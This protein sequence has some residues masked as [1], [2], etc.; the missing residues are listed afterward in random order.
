MQDP[1]RSIT[2]PT[3]DHGEVTLPEPPW[4]LGA[5]VHEPGGYRADILH[6]GPEQTIAFRGDPISEAGLVQLPYGSTDPELGSPTPGVSVSLVQLTLDPVGLY[7]L[8]AVLDRHAE[9]LRGL[10]DEL[11][12]LLAG[13]ER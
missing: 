10:A 12:L 2:L 3:S 4:C 9:Q 7:E 13:S 6:R 5:S 11:T 1:I 8:A